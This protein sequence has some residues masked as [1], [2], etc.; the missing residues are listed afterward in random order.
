MSK[1]LIKGFVV[2][3][4]WKD[5]SNDTA[6]YKFQHYKPSGNSECWDTVLV[7]EH[8][9]EVEVPDDF[10]PIPLQ[11]SLLE[12]RKKALRLKLAQELR[13]IDEEISKLTCITNE[14]AA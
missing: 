12:E 5:S 13:L 11:V 9:F 14:V 2:W 1:H 6:V 8:Q 3:E 10:N 4:K 7:G